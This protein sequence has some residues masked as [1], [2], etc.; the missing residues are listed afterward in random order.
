MFY[1]FQEVEICFLCED[2]EGNFVFVKLDTD[3]FKEPREWAPMLGTR[4][5]FSTCANPNHQ[6]FK[7]LDV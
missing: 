3:L 4:Y 1:T 7:Y 6:E 2:E 5:S